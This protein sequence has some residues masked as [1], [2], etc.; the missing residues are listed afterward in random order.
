MNGLKREF[1]N[2]ANF[3]LKD[4]YG[5]QSEVEEDEISAVPTVLI[6]DREG[7]VGYRFVGPLK[8]E[9]LRKELQKFL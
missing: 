9:V 3:S 6:F 5:S 2:R 1:K 7:R 8:I 4:V